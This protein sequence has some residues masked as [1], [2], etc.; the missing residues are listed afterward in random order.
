MK[1]SNLL[2]IVLFVIIAL[3]GF[4]TNCTPDIAVTHTSTYNVRK[5]QECIDPFPSDAVCDSCWTVYMK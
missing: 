1:T 4:L 3:V 2:I 5:F